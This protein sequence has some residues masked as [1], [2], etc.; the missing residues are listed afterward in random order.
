MKKFLER[1]FVRHPVAT[2]TEICEPTRVKT[3]DD[4]EF[5]SGST[6]SVVATVSLFPRAVSSITT[7]IVPSTENTN[8]EISKSPRKS[9]FNEML[10]HGE[11]LPSIINKRLRKRRKS[12][13]KSTTRELEGHKNFIGKILT[14]S[15]NAQEDLK[16]IKVT[17][18]EVELGQEY[19]GSKVRELKGRIES[20]Y[21]LT[22]DIEKSQKKKS[23]PKTN[24]LV[25][26]QK[27]LREECY[28]L[29][30]ELQGAG[31]TVEVE[32]DFTEEGE[33]DIGM[34]QT[35]TQTM[36]QTE[37]SGLD[38]GCVEER[39][40]KGRYEDAVVDSLDKSESSPIKPSCYLS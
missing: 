29:L 11:H 1:S 24:N 5:K 15:L 4:L 3:S 26:E 19:I 34:S 39:V 17:L 31:W 37:E 25:K 10:D 33:D 21:R 27:V 20:L 40:E 38:A 2:V 18:S 28:E 22:S 35:A 30:L 6:D 8:T 14:K 23:E 12:N 9:L 16:S 13:A 32:D 7:L 36:V